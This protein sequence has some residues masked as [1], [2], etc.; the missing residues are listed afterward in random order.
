MNVVRGGILIK[1]AI[2]LGSGSSGVLAR[3]NLN[4]SSALPIE[5]IGVVGTN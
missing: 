3:R 4:Q 2:K 1:F 5:T